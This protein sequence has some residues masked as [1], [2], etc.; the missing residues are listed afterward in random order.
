[1]EF[2]AGREP[3]SVNLQE[4]NCGECQ[5]PAEVLFDGQDCCFVAT[6]AMEI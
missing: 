4:D 1:V 6:K 5:W 3:A 2:L